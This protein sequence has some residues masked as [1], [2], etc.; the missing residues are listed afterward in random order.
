M[1]QVIE[2]FFYIY[3]MINKTLQFLNIICIC[4]IFF[5]CSGTNSSGNMALNSEKEL[6]AAN[7][8]AIVV[9]DQ[10]FK[11]EIIESENLVQDGDIIV[12]TADNRE[13]NFLRNFSDKDK[14]FSH[15]GVAFKNGDSLFV[16]NAV[17]A[18]L[19]PSKEL[20]KEPYVDFCYTKDKSR[21]GCGIFRY[22][23]LTIA[24]KEAFKNQIFTYYAQKIKFDTAFNL[25]DDEYMYCSEMIAKAFKKATKNRINIPITTK[26]QQEI[27][28]MDDRKIA[29]PSFEYYAMDNIY[30]NQW[31]TEVKRIMIKN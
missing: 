21:K 23:S 5:A 18:G 17:G 15:A 11:Q 28:M 13:S 24:E 27:N 16:Y 26:L 9:N 19:N 29:T 25:K 4:F 10:N 1:P 20:M 14:T 7:L 31:T 3:N 30:F 8:K 22:P 2:A 6:I 12:R